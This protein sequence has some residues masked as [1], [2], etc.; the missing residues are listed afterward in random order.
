[1]PVE[2]HPAVLASNIKTYTQRLRIAASLSDHPHLDVRDGRFVKGR[3]ITKE[4]LSH[5][6]LPRGAEIHL[7]VQD[8]AKWLTAVQK[9]GAKTAIVH[10]EAINGSN[11]I[12]Q[13]G[14][15]N[16]IFL[17]LAINPSTPINWLAKYVGHS[18]QIHV[19][20]GK[21]G[22]YGRSIEPGVYRRI[23]SIHRRWPKI[24]IS[25]DI[26]VT[27]QS[28][29]RLIHSGATVFG[30]GSYILRSSNPRR[31]FQQLQAAAQ[32]SVVK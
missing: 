10:V 20:N 18:K 32:E 16:K 25:C 15:I 21:P 17:V 6:R 3:S 24:I 26:G 14:K 9:S 11:R 7:M 1:M 13:A 5:L 30:V 31:A 23:N 27:P 19:L 12:F 22:K 2:I 28:I 8:P 4:Q 29:G